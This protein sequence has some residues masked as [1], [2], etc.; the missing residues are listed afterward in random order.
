MPDQRE[1]ISVWLNPGAGR[2]G[3]NELATAFLAEA[4]RRGHRAVLLPTDSAEVSLAAGQAEV[5]SGIDRLI[6]IGGDGT[7]HQAIQ[8]AACAQVVLGLLP[9]GSGNDFARALGLKTEPQSAIARALGPAT[10]VDLLRVGDR[11]SATV[12]TVGFSV[13]VTRRAKSIRW[14]KGSAKY[15]AAALVELAT[16]RW[17]P[18]TLDLDG[19]R[20]DVSPNFLAVANTMMFGGGMRIAPDARPDDSCLDVI[21]VGP[22]SRATMLRL[23]SSARRGRH[24]ANDGV[25]VYRGVCLTLEADDPYEV[26]ADGEVVGS[27]PI[28]IEVA[29]GALQL[30]GIG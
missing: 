28:K 14:P 3:A 5:A 18:M 21:V 16:M 20:L 24:V 8:F 13:D 9:A 19:Q 25:D 17:F 1:R 22:V 15:T 6:V 10:P 11:Y 27:L 30:A 2:G 4:A 7:L 12:A 26:H 29:P 23:L